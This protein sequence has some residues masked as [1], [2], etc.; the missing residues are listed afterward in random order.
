MATSVA[1]AIRRS[2]A[3][4]RLVHAASILA[5]AA[6]ID[7]PDLVPSHRDPMMAHAMQ[8]EAMAEFLEQLALA[9]PAPAAPK[10]G[11]K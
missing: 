7:A 9:Q 2:E 3:M 11:R 8:I 6:D 10:R 4:T 1:I 5:A